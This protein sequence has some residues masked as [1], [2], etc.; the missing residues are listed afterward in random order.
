MF[1]L[2]LV[3]CL[4]TTNV[5]KV[6]T[7]A[8]EVGSDFEE[9]AT[10]M[11]PVV[12][13]DMSIQDVWKKFVQAANDENLEIMT[14]LEADDIEIYG[15]S[16]AAMKGS[17]HHIDYCRELFKVPDPNG[18]IRLMIANARKNKDG[19]LNQWLTT[20]AHY[21]DTDEDVKEVLEQHFSDV[22]FENFK[23]KKSMATPEI[24]LSKLRN[25]Y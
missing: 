6:V 24:N 23:I 16:G 10:E 19:N 2:L 18:Q 22:N 5:I 21:T 1:G 4:N 7:E 25:N 14:E 20:S 8:I 11:T 17:K 13:G 15:S 3:G 12:S 9:G